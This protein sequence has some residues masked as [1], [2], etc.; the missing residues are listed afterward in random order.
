MMRRQRSR[1]LA[2]MVIIMVM[3]VLFVLVLSI[4]TISVQNLSDVATSVYEQQAFYTAQAGLADALSHLNSS[5]SW[6]AGLSNVA[7]PNHPTFTYSVTVTPGGAG[8]TAP[9]GTAIPSGNVYLRSTG[10]ATRG[11]TRVVSAVTSSSGLFSNALFGA[12]SVSMSGNAYTDSWDSA[13]GPYTT[14]TSPQTTA[15][16]GT[17]STAAGAVSLVGNA[18]VNGNVIIGPGGNPSTVIA[19]SGT[20]TG[21]ALPEGTALNLPQITSPISGTGTAFSLSGGSQTLSPGVYTSVSATGNSHL[22]LTSGTYY[23]KGDV[24]I[25][26]NSALVIQASSGPVILYV[27]GNFDSS[28]G[29]INNLSGIP[30]NFQIYGTDSSAKLDI[31]GGTAAYLVAYARNAT[32][33]VTGNGDVYGGLIGSDVRMVGSGAVHYDQAV[34]SVAIGATYRLYSFKRW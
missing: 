1:G 10:T 15:P 12:V 18:T 2:I 29:T 24:K 6:T 14:P 23:V 13:S 28:S 25:G 9:D 4:G 3:L 26:G 5:A 7:L 33:S 30:S 31:S 8:V 22:T 19:G 17:N 20:Y 34:K 32:V 27:D 21:S 16:V 11:A